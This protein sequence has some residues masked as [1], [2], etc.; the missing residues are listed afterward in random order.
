MSM[1]KKKRTPN[2]VYNVVIQNIEEVKDAGIQREKLL[3]GSP[4]Y[5]GIILGDEESDNLLMYVDSQK[6]HL[7]YY[8]KEKARWVFELPIESIASVVYYINK[9][10]NEYSYMLGVAAGAQEVRGNDSGGYQPDSAGATE[11]SEEETGIE[12]G[13]DY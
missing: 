7:V 8:S 5:P 13:E 6:L 2:E 1:A 12:E 3:N 10:M 9:I 11:E 4:D